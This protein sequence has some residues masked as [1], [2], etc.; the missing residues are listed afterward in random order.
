MK[1]PPP[2]AR[3]PTCPIRHRLQSP[4]LGC[5]I[6]QRRADLNLIFGEELFAPPPLRLLMFGMFPPSVDRVEGVK[7]DDRDV[8]PIFG[9]KVFIRDE[10]GKRRGERV[11]PHSYFCNLRLDPLFQTRSK[12]NDDHF[13]L[14]PN[15][16]LRS[17]PR[18]FGSRDRRIPE[19]TN[20][21]RP[22]R[23]RTTS[24]EEPVPLEA[25]E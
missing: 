20:A 1:R 2:Q 15:T 7:L 12:N 6:A 8:F 22:A 24:A 19:R 11:H 9:H 13:P 25:R 4:R 16:K 23:S 17:L 21:A 3:C 10:P 14:R 18:S 5:A